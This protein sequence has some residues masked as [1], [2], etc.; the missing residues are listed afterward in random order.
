MSSRR[1]FLAQLAGLAVAPAIPAA[2]LVLKPRALGPS[3]LA[4]M[5]YPYATF[6]DAG[7]SA[8]FIEWLMREAQRSCSIYSTHHRL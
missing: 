5:V 7:A 4:S 6:R 2:P 8:E 3:T 1:A